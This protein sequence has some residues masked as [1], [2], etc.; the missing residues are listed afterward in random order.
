[1]KKKGFVYI[2]RLLSTVTEQ[3][4]EWGIDHET[5]V[6]DELDVGPG[7]IQKSKYDH[8][9]A[10]FTLIHEINNTGK[11]E[12]ALNGVDNIANTVTWQTA[13]DRLESYSEPSGESEPGY[14]CVE[15]DR[16]AINSLGLEPYEKLQ[17]LDEEGHIT[18]QV[19]VSP[20]S[21]RK[22]PVYESGS[23]VYLLD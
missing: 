8:K 7:A 23:T 1:M 5:R 15:L 4:E 9:Q 2:H 6:Y 10:V 17:K 18:S 13:L 14:A 16:D 11:A 19:P 21:P 3:Y 20:G 12:D 22:Q